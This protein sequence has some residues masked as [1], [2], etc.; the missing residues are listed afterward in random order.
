MRQNKLCDYCFKQGHNAWFCRNDNLYTV[1]GCQRKH[2]HLL[3][4]DWKPA[5][6]EED[7]SHA[8][9]CN[10]STVG[11][12]S[13]I[14][15]ESILNQVFLNVV[16]VRVYS[17]KSCVDTLAFLDQSSMTTLCDE[18]LLKSL[19]I[20]GEKTSYSITTVNQISEQHNGQ[21]AKLLISAVT[22]NE[23]IELKR[24]LC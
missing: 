22:S 4:R 6:A 21:N 23:I 5:H 11:M 7:Q 18:H 15:K 8:S 10:P 17:K 3:H 20:S 16:P 19:G 1:K 2:H 9:T 13:S 14:S 12:T 24:L